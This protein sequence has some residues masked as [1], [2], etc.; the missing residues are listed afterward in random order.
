MILKRVQQQVKKHI[1]NSF[2]FLLIAVV[3]IYL[4]DKSSCL[5]QQMKQGL[6][7]TIFPLVDCQVVYQVQM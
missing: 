5:Q 6:T 7:F 3:P 2:M 4:A 1:V